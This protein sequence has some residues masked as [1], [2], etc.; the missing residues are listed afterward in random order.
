MADGRG[1]FYADRLYPHLLEW[2]SGH[3]DDRRRA[4]L[5]RASG[6]VLELGV[7]TGAGLGLYPPHV[8][9]VVGI[10]PH[11]AVLRRAERHLR[12]LRASDVAAPPYRVELEAADAQALPF[13]DAAFDT[14]VAFLTLC[15]VPDPDAAAREARRVL[16]PGGRLLVLE[17]VGAEPGTSLARWQARLDPAWSRLAVGC[18]LDRDTA[19]ILRRA[20]FDTSPLSAYRD[21]ALFPPTAPRIEGVLVR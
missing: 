2:V 17:H 14:V 18:H 1:S 3:F 21:D 19:A 13:E 5:A 20:G 16:K 4:L 15:T 9:E 10:D 8:K 7:G 11:A 12:R 6:R